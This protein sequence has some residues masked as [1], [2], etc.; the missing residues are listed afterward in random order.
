MGKAC[1]GAKS[2]IG[3]KSLVMGAPSPE[4]TCNLTIS[5]IQDGVHTTIHTV[6]IGGL[7]Y[8]DGDSI[9]IPPEAYNLAW[10]SGNEAYFYDWEVSGNLSVAGQYV[11]STTLTVSCG[12]TL[13]LK[14]TSHP[15]SNYDD[16]VGTIWMPEPQG[17]DKREGLTS[18]VEVRDP[19]GTSPAGD[20]NGGSYDKR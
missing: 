15:A 12:G 13:T 2:V 19:Y 11:S 5:V 18:L 1:E 14:L 4:T 6:Q 20:N 10:T 7:T 16:L 17:Y 8:H 9:T 3:V